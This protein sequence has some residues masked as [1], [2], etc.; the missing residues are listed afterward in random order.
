MK[1]KPFLGFMRCEIWGWNLHPKHE[2][3]K[4][5]RKE[6]YLLQWKLENYGECMTLAWGEENL[7]K[8]FFFFQFVSEERNERD[9]W[10]VTKM[11]Q[12]RGPYIFYYLSNTQKSEKCG[13][14]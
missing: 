10:I 1:K 8:L 3:K 4:T 6:T 5:K 9:D 2:I 14:F 11:S 12:K 7:K 13:S